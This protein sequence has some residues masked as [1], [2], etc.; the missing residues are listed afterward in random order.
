MSKKAT[1][2]L[3]RYQI[4]P[5]DRNFQ[6]SL[7]DEE[8]P[9]AEEGVRRK[10]EFFAM[11]LEAIE[12]FEFERTPSITKKIHSSVDFYLYLV[13]ANRSIKRDRSDFTQEQLD[14][15]PAVLVAI[16]NDADK[17]Y[18]VVQ[19]KTRA[20]QDN[21]MVARTIIKQIDAA[22]SKL[23][24][25]VKVEPLFDKNVFWELV[26]KH[27]GSITKVTFEL[28]TPNMANISGNLTDEIKGIGKSTNSVESKLSLESDRESALLI[29]QDNSMLRGM[30]DY[31]GEGGGNIKLRVKNYRK[32]ISTANTIKEV[33]IEDFDAEG[34]VED[35]E[36]ILKELLP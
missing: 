19:Q 18:I 4:L 10:N 3:F 14:N 9:S 35:I 11:A 17:Q 5:V 6:G 20:F 15:W 16:W 34:K 28:I 36:R 27:V 21:T 7:F 32:Q 29:S 30:V 13:S 8:V 12:K 33:E 1:F 26:Q 22:I 25:T 2:N 24:L 23:A 31:A